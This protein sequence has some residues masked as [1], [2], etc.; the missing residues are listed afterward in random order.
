[1]IETPTERLL[2]IQRMRRDGSVLLVAGVLVLLGGLWLLT[3]SHAGPLVGIAIAAGLIGAGVDRLLTAW[4]RRQ[5]FDI[6]LEYELLSRPSST[7]NR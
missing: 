6:E 2:G 5:R 3:T 1:M 7:S 4:R